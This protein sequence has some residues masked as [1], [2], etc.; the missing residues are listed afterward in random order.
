[1]KTPIEILRAKEMEILRLRKE[2]DAL[3]TTAR[4]LFDDSAVPVAGS[5]EAKQDRHHL[6][7]V[8]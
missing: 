2:I 8:P 3:R 6:A 1:M 4:L 5:G 7:E